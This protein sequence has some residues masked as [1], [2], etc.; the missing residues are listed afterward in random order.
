M[1]PAHRDPI[2]IEQSR[3][4]L[5]ELRELS[6]S[7]TLATLLTDDGFEI[8][9]TPD[10]HAADGRLPSM[11]SS[12]QALADA[13]AREVSIGSGEFV[14]IASAHGHVIQRRVPGRPIVLAALFA[15]DETLGSALAA[16][17]LITERLA[18]DPVPVAGSTAH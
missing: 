17:R 8:A 3:R 18:L 11:A 14:I 1:I 16:T 13:V 15:G 5:R 7:L 6:G 9:S 12:I 4:A 2:V 10:G